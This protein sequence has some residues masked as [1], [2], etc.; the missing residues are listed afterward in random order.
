MQHRRHRRF[1]HSHEQPSTDWHRIIEVNLTGTFLMAGPPCPTCSRGGG[2]I[3]NSASTAGLIGQPYSAAYCAS[4]G[5]VVMLTRALAVEYVDAGSRVNA[6]APGGIQTH[7]IESF[8]F[9][10]D[11]VRKLFVKI[12]RRWGSPS[13]RRWPASSPSSR[14]TRPAT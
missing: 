1:A 9:P 6:I 2:N 11:A 14:P 4:K 7:L 5:G 10:P 3:V 8:G 12:T 13:R